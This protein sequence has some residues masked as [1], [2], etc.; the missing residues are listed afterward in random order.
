MSESIEV[1]NALVLH[2]WQILAWTSFDPIYWDMHASL[3]INE[4]RHQVKIRHFKQNCI[5]KVAII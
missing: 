1:I 5:A 4:L 2:M 3:D